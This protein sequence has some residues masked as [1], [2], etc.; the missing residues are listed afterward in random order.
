MYT[1]HPVDTSEVILSDDIMALADMLAEN[2]HDNWAAG[3]I[4]EG[5]TYG[6]QRDDV[7]KHNP[8]LIPYSELS[9]SEKAYDLNTALETLRLIVKLGYN[10]NKKGEG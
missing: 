4:S 10:I 2:T 9:D 1:P 7:L 8:C 6:P 3:R 5:W